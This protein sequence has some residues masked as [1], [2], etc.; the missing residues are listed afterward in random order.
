MPSAHEECGIS[1]SV[2]L[3]VGSRRLGPNGKI[4]T[5]VYILNQKQIAQHR[6]QS[7]KEM[8]DNLL[9]LGGESLRVLAELHRNTK[10]D[11][12][13]HKPDVFHEE[14]QG[15]DNL[16][17]QIPQDDQEDT[18]AH[19]VR[20]L[21]TNQQLLCLFSI[22]DGSITNTRPEYI[23]TLKFT[24]NT[25]KGRR[26]GTA[27]A[28]NTLDSVDD[29]PLTEIAHDEHLLE[30]DGVDEDKMQYH[31]A[32]II[33]MQSAY[34][35]HCPPSLETFPYYNYEE[36]EHDESDWDLLNN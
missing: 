11:H 17:W 10:G 21:L 30:D 9:G 12:I 6:D 31:V 20:D 28:E 3:A 35:Y 15:N 13:M 24:G 5:R 27:S 26:K 14:V 4:S 22:L 29:M 16:K 33:Q 25:M 34:A 18:F 8:L 19:A 1:R 23:A 7:H 2:R 32:G 36:A